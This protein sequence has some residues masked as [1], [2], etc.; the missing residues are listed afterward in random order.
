M[1][2]QISTTNSSIAGET[3]PRR[4]PWTRH[5]LQAVVVASIACSSGAI[6]ALGCENAAPAPS[7]PVWDPLEPVQA[8]KDFYYLQRSVC[9]G[10]YEDAYIDDFCTAFNMYPGPLCAD[11]NGRKYDCYITLMTPA[12]C[13]GWEPSSY[14]D[15]CAHFGDESYDCMIEKGCNPW[16]CLPDKGP[17][18]EEGCICR[19]YC[20]GPQLQPESTKYEAD[21]WPTGTGDT[22]H[23]DCHTDGVIVGTCDQGPVECG[24]E[25]GKLWDNCC[26]QFFK[27]QVP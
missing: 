23:C 8:C 7:E 27:I 15:E 18:G 21:C 25:F 9:D 13:D 16:G 2:D 3:A 14:P 22:W 6:V 11:I 26:N 5:V 20:Y 12:D 19:A 10:G 4:W 24:L 1:P 17:D